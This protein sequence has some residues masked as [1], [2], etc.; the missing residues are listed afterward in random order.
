MIRRLIAVVLLLAFTGALDKSPAPSAAALAGQPSVVP[1]DQSSWQSLK[2]RVVLRNGVEIA[3]VEIGARDAPAVLLLHGYTD[4]SRVWSM[5]A[6]YLRGYRLLIPDQRGHGSSSAPECCYALSDFVEDARQFLDAV[7][8]E[9]AAVVGHSLGSMVGQA[10]AA[11][12]PDRV[13]RIVLA[14]STALAPVRRDDPLWTQI[15]ALATPIAS[16]REF[17]AQWSPA[18]SPTPVDASFL[19]YYEPEIAA[20]RPHVW[21]SVIRE[22]L[23]LPVGRYAADVAAPVAI[24]SA[25]ADPLFG[26]EHHRSLVEA[27][28]RAVSRVLPGLGHNFVVEEP[29]SVGPILAALLAEPTS[30][31]P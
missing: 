8:V 5:V 15:M 22:L 28:P 1:V 17:L 6:P 29:S 11:K 4:N 13:E 9:R 31:K 2:R 30:Q 16:N 14:A 25:G 27:Y 3:Y 12:H 23:D 20:V 24:L 18:A 19:R 26:P 10:L 7:G 21:R